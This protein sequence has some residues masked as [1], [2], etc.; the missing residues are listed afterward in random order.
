MPNIIY[1][2]YALPSEKININKILS[3]AGRKYKYFSAAE[4]N[5][6]QPKYTCAYTILVA[7]ASP[8]FLKF[9][10]VFRLAPR[11]ARYVLCETNIT[12]MLIRIV[13]Y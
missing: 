7:C 8:N 3:C 6:Q 5:N 11:F 12:Y 13:S 10:Q 9:G 2:K 1:I 4:S